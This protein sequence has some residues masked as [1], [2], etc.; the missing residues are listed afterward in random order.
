MI[1]FINTGKTYPIKGAKKSN[2]VFRAVD[3]VN[4]TIGDNEFITIL[5]PSGCGKTTLLRIIAGLVE[6]YDGD[7]RVNGNSIKGPDPSRAMVFQSFALLPWA[8][9]TR[10]VAFGLELAGV[11]LKKRTA[12]AEKYISLV[13]LT[14]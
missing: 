14:G 4:F 13:G 7:V 6:E 9:V 12:I 2:G 8:T 5:G 11:N 1:E 3:D 10:N